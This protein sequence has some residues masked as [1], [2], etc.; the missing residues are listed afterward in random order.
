VVSRKVMLR[1]EDWHEQATG[2]LCITL[3]GNP[4]WFHVRHA[5]ARNPVIVLAP[6]KAG[7]EVYE[8]TWLSA[9]SRQPTGPGQSKPWVTLRPVP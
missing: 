6:T 8:D 3:D 1:V 2:G 5:E 9:D 4:A 7:F